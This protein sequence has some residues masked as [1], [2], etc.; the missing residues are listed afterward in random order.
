MAPIYS[1]RNVVVVKETGIF[2]LRGCETISLTMFK[3]PLMLNVNWKLGCKVG[4]KEETVSI[5]D[6]C[7]IVS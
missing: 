2:R 3:M 5:L 6:Y 4:N 7:N 1:D